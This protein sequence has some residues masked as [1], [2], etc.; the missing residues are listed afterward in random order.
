MHKKI[1]NNT[2]R[3]KTTLFMLMSLD[4]KISTGSVDDRDFDKDFPNISG[5]EQGL[6]QYYDLEKR[7]DIHSFNTGRV[8]A[9]IG[10]NARKTPTT[11][12]PCSFVIVDSSHL[13]AKGVLYLTK[14]TR[15]LYLITTNKKHP[16]FTINNADNLQILYYPKLNLPKVFCDLRKKYGILRI[17]LQSGGTMNAELLRNN[18]IDHISLVVAPALIGGADT[19]TLVDGRSLAT[20]MDLKNIKILKLKKSTVLK[21]SYLHLQYSL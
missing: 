21:N 1:Q 2:V 9:K 6:Y 11:V 16:A 14:L 20:K 5:L 18:L 17:T 8:M 4:G 10:V 12:L 13:T 3:P 7:T 19:S 15:K